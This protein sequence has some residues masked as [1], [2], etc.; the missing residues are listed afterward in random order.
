VQGTTSRAG[1]DLGSP[2]QGFDPSHTGPRVVVGGRRSATATRAR[3]RARCRLNAGGVVR[4]G[5]GHR[6]PGLSPG[7]AGL[8][9]ARAGGRRRSGGAHAPAARV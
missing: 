3:R 1:D 5:P 2:S 7:R 4:R 9:G 6:V 8:G